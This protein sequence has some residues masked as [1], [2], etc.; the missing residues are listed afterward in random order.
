VA[1][2]FDVATDR[3]SLLTAIPDPAA[4]ITIAGWA[5]V[6]VDT[7]NNAVFVRVHAAD[8]A[9]TTINFA[10]ESD[11]LA[12]PGY[13]TGG[14]SL[15]AATGMAVGAWRKVAITC[16]GTTG[17]LYVATPGGVTE[18][19]G[20][21]VGGAASPTGLTF[22]ARAHNDGDEP[23]NGRLAYWRLWSAVLTQTQVEAEWLSTTPV[24]TANLWADWP[25]SSAADLTD[26]S[27]NGRHLS[28]GSTAVTTED[29]PPLAAEVTGTA[30][31]T[32]G[33]LT[34]TATGV[35]SVTSVMIGQLGALT[36]T[37]S[38]TRT[39]V[40][41][42]VAGL[43]ALVG[44][45]IGRR[46]TSGTAVASLGSLRATVTLAAPLP[47][48]RLRASGREPRRRVVGREPRSVI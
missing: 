12:G 31:A 32:F 43:G 13:F 46:T 47:M 10:T 23:L 30:Q 16:T 1:I 11:G 18:V 22:G 9:S 38:G 25:L 40:G 41:T 42:S 2:R 20:G 4:G 29:G 33:A 36:A 27:G 5:Y 3:I 14:G 15:V 39:V 48:T 6:S 19:D 17:T 28:A 37:G 8:G 26:H 7:N 34:G 44:T 35:R 21:T 45:T 24:V